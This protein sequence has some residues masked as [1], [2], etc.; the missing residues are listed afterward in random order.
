MPRSAAKHALESKRGQQSQS[1]DPS[2]ATKQQFRSL[3][4]VHS[5]QFEMALKFPKFEC[6]SRDGEIAN[7]DS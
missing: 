6:Q 4:S 3:Q 7:H 5:L 2:F 1:M